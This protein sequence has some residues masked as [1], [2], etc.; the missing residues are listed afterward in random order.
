MA[1]GDG[2]RAMYR[3]EEEEEEE[4]G[5]LGSWS[6]FWQAQGMRNE[7]VGHGRGALYV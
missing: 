2:G 3:V 6:R 4:G 1:A 7:G 5:G